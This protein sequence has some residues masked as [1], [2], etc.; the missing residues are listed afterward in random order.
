MIMKAIGTMFVIAVWLFT[1]DVVCLLP[2]AGATM[3]HECCELMGEQCGK[4]P[5]PE[6]H[7]CCPSVTPSTAVVPELRPAALPSINPELEL[8]PERS[9]LRWSHF[10]SPTVSPPISTDHFAILRI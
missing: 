9:Q 4:V 6:F 10:E 8:I 5:V 3:S 2:W 7:D 1:P